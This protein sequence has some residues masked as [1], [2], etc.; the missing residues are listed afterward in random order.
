MTPAEVVVVGA[1]PFLSALAALGAAAGRPV[2][3]LTSAA[4]LAAPAPAPILIETETVS[5]D[6]KQAVLAQAGTAS[7][8]LTCALNS[9]AAEAARWAPQ[10]ARVVG[11][12]V[13]PPLPAAGVVEVAAAL[14][15]EAEAVAQADA[16]WSAW[17]QRPVRVADGAGLARARVV[18]A[19]VNEAASAVLE[20]VA[21]PTDIDLAMRLGTN[22]PRGPLA[23][24][25]E[26]GLDTV[27]AVMTALHL[28]W[29]EDRYRP[30]PM[31]RR[32]VAAG[33]LGRKSGR[34]FHAYPTA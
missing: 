30:S 24:G 31:L 12:G 32:L 18:C 33:H 23:W 13:V 25:D 16:L 19:L 15:T 8:V 34:G 3:A 26:I 28:E 27:L 4:Y 7:L 5:L 14:Q 11:F 6:L 2:A 22:Y 9:S 21:S 20:G 17:G 1:E 10:P 29:G